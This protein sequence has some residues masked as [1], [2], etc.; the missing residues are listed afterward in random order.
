VREREKRKG[1]AGETEK[2]REIFMVPFSRC[3]SSP[4]IPDAFSTVRARVRASVREEEFQ[5]VGPE[6]AR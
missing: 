6:A 2:Q 3:A 5:R 4:E 1:R